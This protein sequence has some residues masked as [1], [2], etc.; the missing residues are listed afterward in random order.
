MK[1]P[2]KVIIDDGFCKYE[3]EYDVGE[4]TSIWDIAKSVADKFEIPVPEGKYLGA[5]KQEFKEID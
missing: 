1:V 2:F 5:N 4:D 3:Y